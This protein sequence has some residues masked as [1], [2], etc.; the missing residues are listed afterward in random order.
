MLKKLVLGAVFSL[1]FTATASAATIISD[2]G[3]F[4]LE[5]PDNWQ[6]VKAEVEGEK[7]ILDVEKTDGRGRITLIESTVVKSQLADYKT[8]GD[9]PTAYKT[10][11]TALLS[12]ALQDK[13]THNGYKIRLETKD[14]N[15]YSM[16]TTYIARGHDVVIAIDSL[17]LLNGD[18]CYVLFFDGDK[19][20]FPESAL[21]ASSLQAYGMPLEKWIESGFS[22]R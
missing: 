12:K 8:F 17:V 6:Q 20:N 4:T 15:D 19:K 22:A 18:K 11:L 9:M 3:A 1:V 10:H 7:P 2:D 14:F 5:V 13:V 16:H 21:V